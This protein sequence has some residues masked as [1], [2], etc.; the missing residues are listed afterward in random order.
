MKEIFAIWSESILQT[1]LVVY[2]ALGHVNVTGIKPLQ[3]QQNN[4]S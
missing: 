1:V 3:S 2:K 4:Q